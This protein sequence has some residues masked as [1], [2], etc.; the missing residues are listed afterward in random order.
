VIRSDASRTSDS[1]WDLLAHM[2]RVMCMR[3]EVACAARILD[4]VRTHRQRLALRKVISHRFALDDIDRAFTSSE[5]D[6]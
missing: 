2:Q 1:G 6:G 5:W 4:F 3:P